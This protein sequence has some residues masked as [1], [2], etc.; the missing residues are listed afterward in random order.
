MLII[1]VNWC[2]VADLHI[3]TVWYRDTYIS[4]YHHPWQDRIFLY[5]VQ[6]SMADYTVTGTT[7]ARVSRYLSNTAR[8]MKNTLLIGYEI[9]SC[10]IWVIDGFWDYCN[11][12]QENLSTS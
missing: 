12:Q 7:G 4:M 5:R 10:T 3:F 2:F 6:K 1:D 11:P 8:A 9:G